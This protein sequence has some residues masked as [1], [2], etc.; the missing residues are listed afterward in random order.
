MEDLDTAWVVLADLTDRNA[1]VFYELG[2]RHALKD[3]TILVAQTSDDIPSD[4]QQYA[5]HVYGRTDGNASEEFREKIRD[6]LEDVDRNPNRKDSPVSDFLG[7]ARPRE[8]PA[9][10]A[11][12]LN[13][14]EGRMQA[15]EGGLQLT[16]RP[17]VSDTAKPLASA[18]LRDIP[19]L[20]EETP[21]ASWFEAG[22][23]L[24][25]GKDLRALRAFVRTTL[26]EIRDQVPAKVTELNGFCQNSG[27]SRHGGKLTQKLGPG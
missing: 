20:S 12:R 27:L 22:V 8:H 25:E 26:R 11:T 24:A 4:L 5:Y 10:L 18:T 17:A 14:I 23:E 13:D 15:F 7:S 9:V 2:V 6:L 3:R 16:G 21:P 1:N 19:M